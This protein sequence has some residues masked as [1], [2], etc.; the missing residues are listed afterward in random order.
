MLVERKVM[1]PAP[2]DEIFAFGWPNWGWLK[3]LN[4][5]NRISR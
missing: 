5:S 2:T 4:P 1:E 3:M